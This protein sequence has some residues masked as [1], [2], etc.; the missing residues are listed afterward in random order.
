MEGDE[1]REG[2][3]R[4]RKCLLE[5]LEQRGMVR[6]RSRT[7]AMHQAMLESL[8]A[9]LAYMTDENLLAL[10]EVIER[11]AG[12]KS[13]NIWPEE[14]SVCNWA[15]RLQEPPASESRLVRS[16][17]QSAAGEAAKSGGYLVELF[18]HLKR[19]GAPPNDY[20]RMQIQREADENRTRRLMIERDRE[21]GRASPNDEAWARGYMDMRRRCLEIMKASTGKAA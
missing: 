1:L 3:A 21:R 18:W 7:E 11:A 12:G 13:K 16:Y 9:R 5:P 14:V 20:A 15:R 10:A 19:Y 4:V 6:K 17:L 2:K 8:E